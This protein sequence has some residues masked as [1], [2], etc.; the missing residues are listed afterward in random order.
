MYVP[1]AGVQAHSGGSVDLA[2]FSLHLSGISSMLGAMNIITT[3]INMRAPGGLKVLFLVFCSIFITISV[4]QLIILSPIAELFVI[5]SVLSE[6]TSTT[7]FVFSKWEPEVWN[8]NDWLGCITEDQ[9]IEMRKD[10]HSVIVGSLLGD[11]SIVKPSRGNTY[12]KCKQ[13]IIHTAY[14]AF[15]FFLLAPW[16]TPGS[17]SFSR[18]FDKRYNNFNFSWTLLVSTKHNAELGIDV[19]S[20]VFFHYVNGK[21]VKM[22]PVNVV[23]YFTPIMLAI[24]I[25]DDGHFD[26]GGIYLNVQGFTLEGVNRL[27]EA[28][29]LKWGFI[30]TIRNVSGKPGQYRIYIPA[31]HRPAVQA[32]VAPYMCHSMMYKIGL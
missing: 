22:I 30:C 27:V 8:V 24:W 31:A 28:F 15:L 19:L 29:Y 26:H 23:D 21:R 12:F 32:L 6:D 20:K 14:L 10:I 1:L 16:L 3:I 2:I 4:I 5:K 11:G 13:S 18:F 25:Q 9:L 7:L 17:P